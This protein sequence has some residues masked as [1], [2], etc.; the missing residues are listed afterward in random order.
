V[1]E[2]LMSTLLKASGDYGTQDEAGYADTGLQ[3]D[4]KP[5]YPLKTK[6]TY[7]EEHI[8]AAWNY[9]HKANNRKPYTPE[10]LKLI[11]SRIVHGWKSVIDKNGPPSIVG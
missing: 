3:S 1:F 2:S 11:E 5:R 9:I 7:N 10:Q 6:G 8:R 4:G